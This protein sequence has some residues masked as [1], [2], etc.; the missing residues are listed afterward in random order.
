MSARWLPFPSKS[1]V[2]SWRITQRWSPSRRMSWP[3]ASARPCWKWSPTSGWTS[4]STAS[5]CPT[6]SWDT[7]PRP[8]CTSRWGSPRAPS[9]TKPSGCWGRGVVSGDACGSAR[10]VLASSRQR[11]DH[12]LVQRRLVETRSAAKGLIMAGRVLVD[13]DVV[14]KAGA[15][16]LPEAQL[17]IK[18][19]PRFVS[20]AG[21]KLARALEFFAV[22]PRGRLCLDVGASTGGFVDCL[23]QAGAR[24]VIAVDVG[25][26]QLDSRLRGDPRV[27]V[28][29]R[30]NARHLTSDDLPFAH[31]LV[32]A[33]VSFI[34][35]RKL[36]PAI[37]RV[38][39]PG[40][41]ALLMLKPQFEAGRGRVGKGGIVRDPQIHE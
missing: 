38:A 19:G 14:D 10:L 7:A 3:E 36:V 29:E 6:A 37:M 22:E 41:L 16:V 32:T 4:P 11:L 24:E 34:S 40:F 28:L 27:H 23:L 5:A 20:R 21:E 8:C 13:G 15:Q 1:C 9:A 18:Q 25:Y 30:T 31:E 26:G 2:P 35:L 33:D 17:E 39:A 12:L